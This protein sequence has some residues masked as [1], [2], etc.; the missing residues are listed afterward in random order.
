MCY[1]PVGVGPLPGTAHSEGRG[2]DDIAGAFTDDLPLKL[3]ERKQ[4]VQRQAAE[5]GGGV[6]LLRYGNKT[7]RAP[8]EPVD[9]PREIEKRP[10]Q[11]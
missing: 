5:R 11:A 1:T 2:I 4:E 3:R 7:D 6:E 9:Q 10:A 8:I